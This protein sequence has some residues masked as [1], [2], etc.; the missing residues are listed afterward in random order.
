MKRD[1]L[2]L[3]ISGK[4][5]GLIRKGTLQ[6]G[7]KLPSVRMLCQEY[8]IGMNTAKRVFLE[9]E[10]QS[11]I[12]SKPQ[13]GYFVNQLPYQ[14][15]QLPEVSKPS[16]GTHNKEPEGLIQKVFSTMGRN[17]L[18]LLSMGVPSSELLPLARLNKEIVQATRNLRSAGTAYEPFQG[19]ENLRRMIAARSH[20]WGG[21]LTADDLVT[22][23]GGMNALSFCMMALSQPG[24]TIAMESPCYPGSLQL[25]RSLGLKVLELPT[26]P[27]TGVEIE[28]LKKVIHK[29]DLCLLVPNFNTPLGSCMPTENK[30]A[31]VKL[32]AKHNIPLIEDDIYGDLYFEGQRP[33]CCKTFDTTGNVLWCSAVSKTLAPGYRVGWV[34]PGKYK[35]EIMKLKLV[36]AISSTTIT[37]EAVAN[38]LRSGKYE[39]HLRKLRSNLQSNCDHYTSAIADYFPEDTRVS[40][41]Q[42]GLALWVQFNKAVNTTEL[43]DIAM[44]H[45][46]SIAPGR[47]FT[48]QHQFEHCMRISIGLYWSD[49]VQQQL[50]RLGRLVHMLS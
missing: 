34:A 33:P 13:S 5:A 14:R 15:L 47:M 7:D 9:L 48:L 20:H 49:E 41:P 12:V 21:Q 2:Y 39:S 31:I 37:Q 22:T 29:I 30:K 6:P 18:T 3:D 23:A 11:L 25:A 19:N 26:H 1:F 43:F 16:A 44:K 10:A 8:G 38:F 27:V 28:A 17:D 35:E 42:G 46:I 50:K 40:R 32:L 36:H 24:D 45:K 4:I